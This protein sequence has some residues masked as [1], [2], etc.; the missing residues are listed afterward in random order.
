[1]DEGG[2]NKAQE[3]IKWFKEN[4][5]QDTG[6]W[7]IG[8]QWFDPHGYIDDT[9]DLYSQNRWST[10]KRAVWKFEDESYVEI[11]WE[12]GST[13]YQDPPANIKMVEV[14]PFEKTIIDYRAVR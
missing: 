8:V 2:M 14:E 11:I 5:N 6:M 7:D 3:L 10:Y 4:G 12:D 13:E 9:F 1:M